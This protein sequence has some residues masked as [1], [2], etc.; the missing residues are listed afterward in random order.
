[1]LAFAAT[2]TAASDVS[3]ERGLYLSI[4]GGCHDCHTEGYRESNGVIDPA[5]ALRGH[6]VGWQGPWGTTYATNLRLNV[7]NLSEDGFIL[8]A[9][10][11]ETYPPMPWFNVRQ[12][13]EDDLR[14]LY[15]YI[16]SLGEPGKAPPTFVP[17]GGTIKSSFIILAPAQMPPACTNDFDCGVGEVCGNDKPKRC[18]KK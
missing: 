15:R 8:Y 3:I 17:P 18:V 10:T 1:M 2:S 4:I 16:R 5:R 12:M 7:A 9:K 11:L 6:S 13:S 14:S